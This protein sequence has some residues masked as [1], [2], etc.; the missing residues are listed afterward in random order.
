MKIFSAA[1]IKKWDA[2]T[3]ENEP[4]TSI[5]LME[6]TATACYNWLVENNLTQHH[7]KIFCGK[8]NNGGDG[9]AIA[10]QLL[11]NNCKATLYI[12][13]FGKMGSD[14]FQANL[15]TLHLITKDIHFI[16]SE[17]F[18]PA[19]LDGEI[20]IDAIIGSGFNK[21]LEGFTA[22]L[23]KHIN[24]VCVPTIAIDLP[25]GLFADKSSKGNM[26]IN[27]THTL[28]FQNNKLAFFLPENEIPTGNIHLL[29]IG[30][31]KNF[32][33]DEHADFEM[34]DSDIIKS[35]YKPRTQF[36]NK[37]TYPPKA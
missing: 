34:L 10:R 13:E 19:L 8:G 4:I 15:E 2:F 31:H 36:S 18:F 26:V 29:N 5:N 33:I 28:S 6:R 14:D 22:A 25:T 1:Q 11:Q 37:G 7:F 12:L 3:I 35:I 9:L 20:I 30:L 24:N 17:E 23:A 32:E 21:P 27:A 16:Q